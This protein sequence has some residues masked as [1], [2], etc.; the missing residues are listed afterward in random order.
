MMLSMSAKDNKTK[1]ASDVRA[2]H[3]DADSKASGCLW[4][5]QLWCSV[6]VDEAHKFRTTGV[7][8]HGLNALAAHS[9]LQLIATATVLETSPMVVYCFSA[10]QFIVD[11]ADEV[12][13]GS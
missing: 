3:R 8:F 4:R 2:D 10:G 13:T 1:A 7:S 5:Q 9:R 6:F 12:L 11:V